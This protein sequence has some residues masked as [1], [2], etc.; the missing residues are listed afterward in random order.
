M[1]S[2]PHDDATAHGARAALYS[3]LAAAFCYPTAASMDTLTDPA[4]A[5]RLREAGDALDLGTE[6]ERLLDAFDDADPDAIGASHTELFGLPEAGSYPVVPYE[7]AYTTPDDIGMEQRRIAAVVGLLEAFDLE[8]S[9]DFG[10]RPDH[11]SVELELMQVLAARRQLAEADSEADHADTLA[12]AEA[13]VLEEHLV[14][15]VPAFAHDLRAAT[16]EPVYRAA[17]DLAEGLV[18]RDHAGREPVA[19]P[20]PGG[21]VA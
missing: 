8:P 7:A 4:V 15:F 19:V 13:T 9:D 21:D 5:D 18:T 6:T 17:A 14:D 16:D 1:A 12:A 2:P 11:V 20:T 10:E 3:A